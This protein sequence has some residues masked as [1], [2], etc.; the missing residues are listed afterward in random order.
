MQLILELFWHIWWFGRFGNVINVRNSCVIIAYMAFI[1]FPREKKDLFLHMD[2]KKAF[3]GNKLHSQTGRLAAA[4]QGWESTEGAAPVAAAWHGEACGSLQLPLWSSD[5]RT[6]ARVVLSSSNTAQWR[7]T[8][9]PVVGG[10]CSHVSCV[11]YNPPSP[12]K[13]KKKTLF[14][15]RF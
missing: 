8:W 14:K 6:E 2:T 4:S 12:Q 15:D 3:N 13:V 11:S 7:R 1:W 9:Q 5:Q 10:C